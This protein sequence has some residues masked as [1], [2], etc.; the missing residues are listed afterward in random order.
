MNLIVIASLFICSFLSSQCGYGTDEGFQIGYLCD[1]SDNCG[2]YSETIYNKR[3]WDHPKW[4]LSNVDY[5]YTLIQLREQST[6]TPVPMD[7]NSTSLTYD[8]GK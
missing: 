8:S 6:I 2:Q 4:D 3:V 5:D 1:E 7:M